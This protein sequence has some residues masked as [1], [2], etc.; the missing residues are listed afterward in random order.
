M[1]ARLTGFGI[2]KAFAALRGKKS[3][4]HSLPTIGRVGE[5][6]TGFDGLDAGGADPGEALLTALLQLSP[7]QA[8][9]VRAR[10]PGRRRPRRQVGPSAEYGA[11]ED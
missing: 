9:A 3:R 2:Q 7:E 5:D 4:A 11:D 10:T 8:A 6:R 1:L